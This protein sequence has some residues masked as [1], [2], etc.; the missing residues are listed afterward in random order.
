VTKRSFWEPPS[1]RVAD[2]VREGV[3]RML[4][5]LGEQV[6][7]V[8][9]A[10]LEANAQLVAA[11]PRL[12]DAVRASTRANF[13]HWATAN[14]VSPGMPVAPYLG[15]ENVD[16]AREVV[17]HG[18]DEVIFQ[19]FH[20]GQRVA[21]EQWNGLAFELTADP[22]ELR[23]FVAVTTR[24]IF[25][26]VDDTLAALYELIERERGQITDTTHLARLEVVSLVLEGAPITSRRASERLRYELS[27]RHTAAVIWGATDKVDAAALEQAAD[28]LTRAAGERR[29]LTVLASP[30]SLWV[31]VA[32]DSDPEL[33]LDSLRATVAGSPDVRIAIGPTGAGMEGFRRSHLDAAVTQRLMRR[34]P[35]S[36]QVAS[37]DDVETVA[38]A[39]ENEERAREFV[40]RTLG[41]LA[42]A[43][44]EL[45]DTLRV[46]LREESNTTATATAMFAHRNTVL[47]RLARARELLPGPLEGRGLQI[48]LALEIVH[49]LG[50]PAQRQ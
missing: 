14:Y 39:V 9:Q 15:A 50:T 11:D 31:W 30:S 33:D 3:D 23:E 25:A 35:T 44:P 34:L 36:A 13:S 27:R 20:A 47:S 22:A 41:G 16:L 6:A 43:A 26:F 24:S 8:D 32:S 5:N 29:A 38:L 10:A 28:A 42:S 46:Y 49:V 45:R 4:G 17:R 7:A 1:D 18:L 19:S 2:L 48:A 37:Y 40:A 21:V 12:A